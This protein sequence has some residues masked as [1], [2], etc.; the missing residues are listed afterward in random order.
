MHQFINVLTISLQLFS[1][2][3][4]HIG[5]EHFLKYLDSGNDEKNQ[6]SVLWQAHIFFI[7]MRRFLLTLEQFLFEKNII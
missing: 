4:S 3:D 2:S 6:S 7:R 1:S 5:L